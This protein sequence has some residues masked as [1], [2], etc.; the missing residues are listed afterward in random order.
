MIKKLGVSYMNYTDKNVNDRVCVVVPIYNTEKYLERCLD[1]LINQ[2]YFNLEIILVNDGS[3][4]KSLEICE[5]QRKKDKRIKIINKKNGGLS[6]AR[7]A[8][9]KNCNSDYIMFVDSDDFL[10]RNAIYKM[11]YN[12]K[13]YNAD[14]SCCNMK[15]FYDISSV[16][17]EINNYNIQS[18]I[19]VIDNKKALLHMIDYRKNVFPNACNKI[20]KYQLFKDNIRYPEGKFYEDMIVTAKVLSNSKVVVTD[21]EN[22]YYYFQ[23][24]NSIVN[25]SYN[26]KDLDH[27]VMSKELLEYIKENH[28]EI[29]EE[30]IVYDLLNMLSVC[31]KMI[32]SNLYN[33]KIYDKTIFEIKSKILLIYKSKSINKIKKM[34]IIIFAY[35]NGIY[36]FIIRRKGKLL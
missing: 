31:N 10:K 13:E 1:S 3:T 22:M 29:F 21:N 7:N 6:T 33:K 35:F 32:K 25:I 14:I 19:E 8:G 34:Q 17:E 9:I 4:D 23:R 12:I 26:E 27:I 20:Y 24:A 36:K 18:K 11:M 2:T 16:E 28:F 30:Y 15:M 5:K